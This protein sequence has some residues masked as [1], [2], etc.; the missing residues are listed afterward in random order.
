MRSKGVRKGVQIL[1]GIDVGFADGSEV[2]VDVRNVFVKIAEERQKLRSVFANVSSVKAKDVQD[3]D[4]I[5]FDMNRSFELGSDESK[6]TL[7]I[8]DRKIGSDTLDEINGDAVFEDLS[9]DRAFS[10][11]E[12][13]DE[14]LQI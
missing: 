2:C 14:S 1:D 9:D 12:S 8:D 7:A 4:E 5:K 6:N 13:H 3:P 10:K 11:L